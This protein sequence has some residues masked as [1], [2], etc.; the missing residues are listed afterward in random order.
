MEDRDVMAAAPLELELDDELLNEPIKPKQTPYP[1]FDPEEGALRASM[2][3][4]LLAEYAMAEARVRQRSGNKYAGLQVVPTPPRVC[5]VSRPGG[6][7]MMNT[8]I[9]Q[10]LTPAGALESQTSLRRLVQAKYPSHC[11]PKTW[12]TPLRPWAIAKIRQRLSCMG[13]PFSNLKV[14]SRC[15]LGDLH[16]AARLAVTKANEGTLSSTVTLTISDAN[17]AINGVSFKISVNTVKGKSYPIAR[18][19]VDKLQAA[20]SAPPA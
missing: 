20:L 15:S 5:R 12:T 18:I 8:L 7:E 9:E 19:S 14:S 6:A 13:Q 3:K 4:E 1:A 11:V 17:I 2:Q 16:R 10:I